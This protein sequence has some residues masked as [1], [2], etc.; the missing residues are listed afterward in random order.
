MADLEKWQRSRG[1]RRRTISYWKK[2]L[3]EAGIDWTNLKA[4]TEDRKKWKKIVEER[5]EHLDKWEKSRGHKWTGEE[6]QRNKIRGAEV[7]FECAVCGKR[8]KSKGGLVVHRRRMHEESR[9]KKTFECG[10]GCGEIFKQ[11]ANKWNH[12]KV[13]GGAVVDEGRRKC[14]CGREFAKSYINRHRKKCVAAM[15]SVEEEAV[16]RGPKKYVKKRKTCECG[17]EMDATNYARHRREA[18]PLGEEGP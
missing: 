17:R 3:K 8:C 11:E 18:C 14:A 4:L 6:I 9:L 15:R 16:E 12:E 13:C 5:T 7:V 1:R 2:L 10:K